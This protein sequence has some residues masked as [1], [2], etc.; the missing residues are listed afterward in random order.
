[1]S[2]EPENIKNMADLLR[3]GATLTELPCPAC[4]SPLFGMH[5]GELWCAQCKKK[6]IV[7]KEGTPPV[8]ATSA[9]S[10]TKLESTLLKKIEEIEGEIDEEKELARLQ[11]LGTLLSLLLENLE[12][13]R[14]TRK[15]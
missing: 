2:R 4:S 8:E 14:R 12:K 1:M 10:L 13:V 7:V 5:N 9:I 15:R 11:E 6:V 3:Q